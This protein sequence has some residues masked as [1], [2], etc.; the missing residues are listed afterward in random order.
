[1]WCIWSL[2]L[3]EDWW[4]FWTRKTEEK[5]ISRLFFIHILQ[6]LANVKLS[7]CSSCIT[8]WKRRW[9]SCGE[10]LEQKRVNELKRVKERRIGMRG[11]FVFV[12]PAD[13]QSVR[14]MMRW[15]VSRAAVVVVQDHKLSL[16][17]FLVKG[18][19]NLVCISYPR[20]FSCCLFWLWRKECKKR[21][22]LLSSHSVL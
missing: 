15:G 2:W 4:C 3:G 6:H 21:H 10:G 7:R 11:S 12:T 17:L 1:M 16:L 5:G 8:C 19:Q 14:M 13:G 9:M 22:H 20:F 18:Y